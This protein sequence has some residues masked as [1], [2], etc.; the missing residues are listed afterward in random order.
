M[1]ACCYKKKLVTK[2]STVLH[3][4]FFGRSHLDLEVFGVKEEDLSAK[5]YQ[6]Q[7]KPELEEFC[8][9]SRSLVNHVG[10]KGKAQL[11]L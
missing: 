5:T 7:Q 10:C 9:Q 4:D 3:C 11:L 2:I 6:V 1:V 8:L